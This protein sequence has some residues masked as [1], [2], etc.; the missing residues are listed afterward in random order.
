MA[1]P[2]SSYKLTTEE[3]IEVQNFGTLAE[4]LEYWASSKEVVPFIR[5]Q[6]VYNQ[7]RKMFLHKD[8]GISQNASLA[9]LAKESSV[10][11]KEYMKKC[12]E[13]LG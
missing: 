1:F 11:W 9:D 8:A 13:L 5:W 2:L 3:Y 10:S 4:A 12:T 7:I 6:T